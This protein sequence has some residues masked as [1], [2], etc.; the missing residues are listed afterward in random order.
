MSVSRSSGWAIP[1]LLIF[2]CFTFV[3]SH[4]FSADLKKLIIQSFIPNQVLWPKVFGTPV[5]LLRSGIRGT[6]IRAGTRTDLRRLRTAIFNKFRTKK[7][8]TMLVSKIIGT[9]TAR[10]L[11]FCGDLPSPPMM[12]VIK[13]IISR[14]QKTQRSIPNSTE[15]CVFPMVV[16]SILLHAA[17]GPNDYQEDAPHFI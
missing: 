15:G 3:Q 10:T 6:K 4:S 7:V 17:L 13:S 1:N 12:L 14:N 11:I 2:K 9:L 8:T 5:G 16:V